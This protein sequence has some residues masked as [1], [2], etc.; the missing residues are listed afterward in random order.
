MDLQAVKNAYRRHAPYYDAVFGVLLG[1]GRRQTV[2]LANKAAK[3]RVLEVGVGTG[4]S[5]PQYRRDLRVV[6]IDI[7]RDMLEIA[8]RRVAAERLSHVEA[9]HEMDAENLA[10]EDG[11]FDT[12]CAMYVASVVPNPERLMR[13]LQ[14]VCKPGGTVLI[15][16]HFAEPKGI[17]ALFT[18]RLAALSDRLGWRPDFLLE[19]FMAHGTLQVLHR[20]TAPPFGLFTIL[21]CRNSTIPATQTPAFETAL[22]PAAASAPGGE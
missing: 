21:Q 12:V 14:R 5:L 2:A 15:V 10:F 18:R 1:P 8:R 16:N 9:L 17:R 19:P 6:G 13:E 4:L 3:R 20:E 11:S 7:S 22:A